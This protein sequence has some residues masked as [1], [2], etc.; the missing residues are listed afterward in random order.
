[1]GQ[2]H[3][4]R[5]AGRDSDLKENRSRLQTRRKRVRKKQGPKIVWAWARLCKPSIFCRKLWRRGAQER[6]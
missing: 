2:K 1:M 3:R 5:Q 4:E 6:A